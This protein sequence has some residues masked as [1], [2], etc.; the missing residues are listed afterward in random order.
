LQSQSGFTLVELLLVIA[1]ISILAMVGLPAYQDYT[2]R[3]KVVEDF[4]IVHQ[5]KLQVLEFYTYSGKLPEK[6]SDV[7]LPKDKEITGVRLEKLKIDKKPSPGTI[8][9]YYDGKDALPALGKNNEIEF[10]P[11]ERNGRLVWDCTGG[12]MLDKYRPA[13]CRGGSRGKGKDKG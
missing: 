4:A 6:N 3:T 11:E 5:I 2:V 1:I 13:N 12:N 7:G 8:R 10:V 9:L